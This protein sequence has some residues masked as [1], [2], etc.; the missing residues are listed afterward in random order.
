[1]IKAVLF[2]LD[3]TL[4]NRDDSVKLFINRQYERLINFVGHIPK[5]Q[6]MARFIEL[7]QHGYVWKDKVYQQL[8]EEL[9][10]K[11]IT[12]KELLKD[13]I[14]EFKHSCV[15]FPNLTGMLE[16]LKSNNL[17]LG[18]ITNGYGQFQTDNIMSLD[19]E[20]YFDVILVSEWEGL[21][22]PD[23][24]LFHRALE[25]LAV[26]PHESIFIGD[27]PLNDVKAAK[28][29]GMKGI[30]KRNV[31]YTNVGADYIV[32]DLLD[33]NEVIRMINNDV[34]LIK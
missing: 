1:M 3:G 28:N 32:D 26:S 17:I 21:K 30:W 12:W 19:I 14:S 2:D 27:H 7:D 25:K 13:Y 9:S 4:L 29:V 18:M 33:L 5:E 22:K 23:P 8:V 31:H 6:Y 20:K 34:C 11:E 24:R 16:E 15:P 10:I